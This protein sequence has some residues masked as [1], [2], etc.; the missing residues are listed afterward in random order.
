MTSAYVVEVTI[1][2]TRM[3]VNTGGKIGTVPKFFVNAG[4]VKRALVPRLGYG[5]SKY[6]PQPHKAN[7]KVIKIDNLERGLSASLASIMTYDEFYAAARSS[8]F[9][10][11]IAENKNAVYKIQTADGKFVNAGLRKEKFG[12][13]WNTSGQL[14]SHIT[15]RLERLN[16]TSGKY[17]R[18]KVVEIEYAADGITT[19]QVKTYPIIDF[20]CASPSSL[21][22]YEHKYGKYSKEPA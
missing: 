21:V 20:Y 18:A 15:S 7:T 9:K 11:S 12:K 4:Q 16:L 2:S 17:A 1:D 10:P 6:N 3:Y 14:R 8:K 13:S 5:N 19:K 22:Q